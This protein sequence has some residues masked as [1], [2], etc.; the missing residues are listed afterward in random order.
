VKT[1]FL[2]LINKLGIYRSEIH[3]L[4]KYLDVYGNDNRNVKY[5]PTNT[6]NNDKIRDAFSWIISI[7]I[8]KKPKSNK[9]QEQL[10][11]L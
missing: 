7:I 2:I 1:P 10:P 5:I 6:S 8:F 9:E 4:G 3:K 11:I